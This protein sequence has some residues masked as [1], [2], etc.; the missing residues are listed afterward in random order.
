[1][2]P[3]PLQFSYTGRFAVLGATCIDSSYLYDKNPRFER[4]L[5]S[6][7]TLRTYDLND[8]SDRFL[9]LRKHYDLVDLLNRF[10]FDSILTLPLTSYLYLYLYLEPQ[11]LALNC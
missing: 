7:P 3:C 9:P 5:K 4:P 6:I 10:T 8:P 1:V 2:L 11:E